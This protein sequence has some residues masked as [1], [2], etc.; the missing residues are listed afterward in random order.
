MN[1]FV[2]RLG[3]VATAALLCVG[4]AQSRGQAIT[5]IRADR[6]SCAVLQQTL[7]REG[8]AVIRWPSKRVSNYLLYDRY[9]SPRYRCRLGWEPVRATVPAADN[10][11][12]VVHRCEEVEPLFDFFDTRRR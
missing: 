5:R 6:N 1:R 2:L 3:A 4:Q 11:R 9:V 8:A 12:C 10:P 7:A